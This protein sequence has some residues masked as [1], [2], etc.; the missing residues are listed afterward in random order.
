MTLYNVDY[1]LKSSFDKA[2][3]LVQSREQA[4]LVYYEIAGA[5]NGY[6]AITFNRKAVQTIGEILNY[7][8]SIFKNRGAS[9]DYY[10]LAWFAQNPQGFLD[11]V[12]RSIVK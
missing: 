7:V 11:E 5:E 4:V 3:K 6:A 10:D 9:L 8:E 1:H 12:K 2:L